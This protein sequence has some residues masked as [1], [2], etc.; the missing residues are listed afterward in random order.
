MKKYLLVILLVLFL[1]GCQKPVD[2]N[3]ESEKLNVVAST[4]MLADLVNQIGQDKVNLTMLFGPGI[5]PHL[6][7]PT[8]KDTKAIQQADIVFFSGL[9]L[10]A[11]FAQILSAY[12]DKTVLVGELLNQE[13]LLMVEEENTVDPH[14]WF[15]VPLWIEAAEIVGEHL[16]L[17]DSVNA[18][19]YQKNTQDYIE[20]LN[21]L[22]QWIIDRVSELSKD[23]RVLVTAHDAFNYFA[24]TYGFEVA[25]IAGISTEAE[26]TTKDV[27][28][29]ADVIIEKNVRSIFIESTIP[30]TIVDSVI[31]E[32]NRRGYSVEIG[33]ELY[34]DALGVDEDAEYINAVKHNVNS[35]VDGLK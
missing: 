31:A 30:M 33:N 6:A 3:N 34:S 23:N 18:D 20:Q 15:S 4:S 1:A 32:V 13:K 29:T 12:S 8:G 2:V 7:L 10:E 22:H 11:Q 14:F 25:A 9:D 17:K 24:E 26:V 28:D 27:I 35:I 5:D 19:F 16:A 21:Q